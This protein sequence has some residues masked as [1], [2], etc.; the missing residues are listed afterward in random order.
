MKLMTKS[1]TKKVQKE[2]CSK[3]HGNSLHFIV[4]K[5]KDVRTIQEFWLY[6]NVKSD[7]AELYIIV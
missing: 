4:D 5:N 2:G 7:F 6:F 1:C 3:I